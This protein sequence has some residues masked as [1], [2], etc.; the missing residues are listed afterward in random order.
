M[1][2]SC[3]NFAIPKIVPNLANSAGC[4][5]NLPKSN[6]AFAPPTS[7][8]INKTKT[9]DMIDTKYIIYDNLKIILK[10]TNNINTLNINAV[11]TKNN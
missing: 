7:F 2:L 8:P 11:S 1:S 5:P 10:S 4:K 3:I 6:Q 9:N